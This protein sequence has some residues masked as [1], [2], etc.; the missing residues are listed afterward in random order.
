MIRKCTNYTTPNFRKAIAKMMTLTVLG[1]AVTASMNLALLI[2]KAKDVSSARVAEIQGGFSGKC[3]AHEAI[4]VISEDKPFNDAEGNKVHFSN[5]IIEH[6]VEGKRRRD[7]EPK[8]A[9][10]EDLPFAIKAV[11]SDSYGVT[12]LKYP[13]GTTPDPLDPP[14]GTQR[15]YHIN[16]D[17]G[18]L[19]VFVY[20]QGG[21]INGWHVQDK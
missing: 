7:N 11:K 10:L 19:K 16:T 4:A 13:H 5:D 12:R 20:I 2:E 15:E 21:I 1:L 18:Q 17:R 9:N 8:V 3:K 6:Y 14:R